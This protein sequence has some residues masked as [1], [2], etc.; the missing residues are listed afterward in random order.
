MLGLLLS[1]MP[2]LI[3]GIG[4]RKEDRRKG[5][6]SG[7]EFLMWICMSSL[8]NLGVIPGTQQDMSGPGLWA[9]DSL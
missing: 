8:I 3:S 1:H 9:Q 7:Q 2:V 6:D 4:E 5:G